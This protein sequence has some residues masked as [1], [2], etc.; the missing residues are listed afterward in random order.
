MG[1]GSMLASPPMCSPRAAEPTEP[2][3]WASP[4]TYAHIAR[5]LRTYARI[6]QAYCVHMR[7]YCVW[8]SAEGLSLL[9]LCPSPSLSLPR[10]L[11]PQPRICRR[12]SLALGRPST[13]SDVSTEQRPCVTLHLWVRARSS[14]SCKVYSRGF[15]TSSSTFPP[16]LKTG[17]PSTP[18]LL[19]CPAPSP[20][21][22]DPLPLFQAFR[23]PSTLQTSAI[24]AGAYATHTSAI[25]AGARSPQL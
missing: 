16:P 18:T 11:L 10:S 3:A 4:C 21:D 8:P 22:F 14:D 13:G 24:L 5:I 23:G 15:E 12:L 19:V 6:L 9:L 20:N 17:E 1:E 7:A 2:A 25:L